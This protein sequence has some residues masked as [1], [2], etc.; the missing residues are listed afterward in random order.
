LGIGDWGLGIGP[1]PQSPIPNPQSPI[2]ISFLFIAIYKQF[3]YKIK[4]IKNNY[5]LKMS[6]LFLLFLV[7]PILAASGIFI[8][9]YKILFV[10]I[11]ILLAILTYII[12]RNMR[13][14]NKSIENIIKI[15][16]AKYSLKKIDIGEFKQL[17]AYGIMTFNSEIYHIENLGI[18]SILT[19]NLGFMQ[20]FTLQIVS[21]E[22]DL[23]LLTLDIMYIFN[24]RILLIEIYDL[25]IDN[26]NS[27]YKSFL[28]KVEN[29]KSNYSNFT[30]FEIKKSWHLEYLSELVNKKYGTKDEQIFIDLLNQIMNIFIEYSNTTKKIKNVDKKISLVEDFGNELMDKGGVSTDMF[31]RLFGVEKTRKYLGNVLFGYYTFKEI[32]GLKWK[33]Y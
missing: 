24:K 18:L 23:P 3:I 17:T 29:I 1:N 16:K 10:I 14:V 5:Y 26:T 28:Q 4:L 33:I 7:I 2:P 11:S 12:F 13:L 25:M 21:F 27:E 19:S 30:N 31:K 15:I 32:V 20:L 6:K 8:F 9:R 22:K